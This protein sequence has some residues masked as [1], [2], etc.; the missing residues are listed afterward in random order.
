MNSTL[1][2]ISLSLVIGSVGA[3]AAGGNSTNCRNVVSEY[4]KIYSGP[5]SCTG[6]FW[7][8]TYENGSLVRKRGSHTLSQDVSETNRSTTV[9]S[10]LATIQVESITGGTL[11]ERHAVSCVASIPFSHEEPI[12]KEVCDKTPY[13][14]I[15]TYEIPYQT[16]VRMSADDSD[17]HIVKKEAWI[18]GR[19]VSFGKHFLE[20]MSIDRTT[21]YNVR[22]KVTDN[23]GYVT[24]VSKTVKASPNANCPGGP[25]D[26]TCL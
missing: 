10:G 9:I 2:A 21:Y 16:E 1:K 8:A 3:H 23:D 24:E 18:D 22:I 17:G 25:N 15:S 4:E 26:Y 5:A 6:I 20:A 12:Y 19:R 13:A 11:T 7:Y 14:Y